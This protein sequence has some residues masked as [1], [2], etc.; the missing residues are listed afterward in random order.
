MSRQ[1]LHPRLQSVIDEADKKGGTPPTPPPR[2]P[3]VRP[4][5]PAVESPSV[6]ICHE[7]HGERYYFV[8]NDEELFKAALS[9][10]R[11]RLK[12]G[13]WYHEPG[14][15][16]TPPDYSEEDILKLPA[17]LQAPARK[18]VGE[19]KQASRFW[20]DTSDD[21]DSVN[22]ICASADGS[23]AWRLLRDRS[24]HECERVSLER[25]SDLNEYR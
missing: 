11:G 3:K 7:K 20:Q 22:S 19:Y 15:P 21:W 10:V 17:S 4:K 25:A 16:P 23:A 8:V 14:S 9:I 18:K 5:R 1:T 6:L 12:E 24:D 2:G 13:Y